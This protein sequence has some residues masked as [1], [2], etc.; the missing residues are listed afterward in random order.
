MF[1][2]HDPVGNDPALVPAEKDVPSPDH[3]CL[4]RIY[5]D[6]VS[7]KDGWVHAID[8]DENFGYFD[9][10]KVHEEQKSELLSTYEEMKWWNG[11][12]VDN[13][14]DNLI[15][16]AKANVDW[17]WD[18]TINPNA[19]EY[20]LLTKNCQHYAHAVLTE[21]YRIQT[22]IRLNEW[23]D[24]VHDIQEKLYRVINNNLKALPFNSGPQN[25]KGVEVSNNY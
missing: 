5:G 13:L 24:K 15:R 22:E 17:N 16:L 4:H 23:L 3:G 14:D 2:A 12:R 6:G 8:I 10:S 25:R 7:V 11:Y 1:D 21:Y 19:D 9:D 18:T 20:K